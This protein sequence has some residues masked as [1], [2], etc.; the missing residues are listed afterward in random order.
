M[1]D[2]KKFTEDAYEQTHFVALRRECHGEIG[3]HGALAHSALAGTDGNHVFHA[4]QHLAGLGAVGLNGF[5]L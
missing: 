1:A 3:C 2:D 5:H 4:G